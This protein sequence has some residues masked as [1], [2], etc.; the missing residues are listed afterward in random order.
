MFV[1]WVLGFQPDLILET[2]PQ[3]FSVKISQKVA[4]FDIFQW[5][6]EKDFPV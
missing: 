1:A 6:T 3:F 2:V 4:I 5:R